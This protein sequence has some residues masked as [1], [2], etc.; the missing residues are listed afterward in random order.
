MSKH[1]IFCSVLK[2]LDGGHQY[3]VD[4]F[5]A[6]ADFKTV[7]EEAKKQTV[8]ELL[9]K[10][11]DS[12]G[13][14][15]LTAS[16][17]LRACRNRHLGTI[18]RCCEAW[19]LLGK[20]FDPISFECVDFQRLSLIIANFTRENLAESEAEMMNLR[21]KDNALTRCRIGLRAWRVKKPTLCLSAVIDE[22]GHPL[23]HDEESGRRFCEYR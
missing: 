2:R 7:L 3:L 23:E 18:I 22:E 4:P 15:L 11:P 10:R 6:L 9:S 16:T 21:Q 1:P 20:C 17:A 13:A 5:C 14:K 12:L 8:R 19:E